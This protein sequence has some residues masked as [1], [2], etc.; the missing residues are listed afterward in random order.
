MSKLLHCI[1]YN[2][3]NPI[4]KWVIVFVIIWAAHQY[5]LH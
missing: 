5:I 1:I 4:V 2:E 3:L